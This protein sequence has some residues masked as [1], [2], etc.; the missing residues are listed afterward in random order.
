MPELEKK[1]FVMSATKIFANYPLFLNI[2]LNR[3]KKI[4]IFIATVELAKLGMFKYYI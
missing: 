2:K 3:N 4:S 1:G